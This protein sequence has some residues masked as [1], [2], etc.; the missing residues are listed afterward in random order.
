MK[1]SRCIGLVEGENYGP[2]ERFAV[3]FSAPG[4]TTVYGTTKG[5]KRMD[6]NGS[7]KSMLMDA[8]SVCLYGRGMRADFAGDDYWK[9]AS[10]GGMMLRVHL[11]GYGRPLRVERYR[12]HKEFGDRI[13]IFDN[14]KEDP[15]SRRTLPEAQEF[16]CRDLLGA[17]WAD[18][19]ATVA[20]A[21][22]D[23]VRAFLAAT[24]TAR[25]GVLESVLKLLDYANA[26]ERAKAEL[27]V[28][29]DALI[30]LRSRKTALE[31]QKVDAEQ[32]LADAAA[33]MDSVAAGDAVELA[34]AK[35]R[36]NL[37]A[38]AEVRAEKALVDLMAEQEAAEQA[39]ESRFADYGRRMA[40]YRV[41][42]GEFQDRINRLERDRARADFEYDTAQKALARIEGLRGK[43]PTCRRE[44]T[45]KDSERVVE[46]LRAQVSAAGVKSDAI[47]MELEMVAK[48][49][50]VPPPEKPVDVN[51]ASLRCEVRQAE[52]RLA[53]VRGKRET[54]A[55]QLDTVRGRADAATQARDSAKAALDKVG[56]A[57]AACDAEIAQREDAMKMVEFWV[58]GYGNKGIKSLEIENDLPRINAR[59]S[60]YARRLFGSDDVT[61]RLMALKTLKGGGQREEMSV[62]C[63]I[64]GYAMTYGQA[65]RG[66]RRRLDI[67][68]LM[69]LRSVAVE[70]SP[71]ALNQFF[72][73]E[74]FDGVD[75]AGCTAVIELLR[76]VSQE[77][78]VMLVTHTPQLRD[79]GDRVI[80]VCHDGTTSRI[81]SGGEA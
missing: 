23:D 10:S 37:W 42:Q 24:D 29:V 33:A 68:F 44:M 60:Y 62:A 32:R 2:Y 41:T 35:V 66:M 71:L 53:H 3:D 30:G 27:R 13:V 36:A 55:A 21:C 72:A 63:R 16:I 79:A 59:F 8:P 61:A 48:E 12:K 5:L 70:K 69:A 81:L 80:H 75:Q 15:H 64:P 49:P 45:G 74:V 34:H 56:D 11:K 39:V 22:R 25:K 14:N 6:G 19:A 47:A 28:H 50:V 51:G 31:T 40:E 52:Q 38:L 18:Y 9:N 73:D 17:T 7:G 46:E 1:E 78:P 57:A 77:C 76:E 65:S 58:S 54:A 43:C 67:A 20:F 26:C 4:L